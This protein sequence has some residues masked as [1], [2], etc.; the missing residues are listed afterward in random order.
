MWE[1]L[2]SRRLFDRKLKGEA[3]AEAVLSFDPGKLLEEDLTVPDGLEPIIERS[4][5]AR[6]EQ[7]YDTALEF[8]EDINDYAY[9]YGIRLLDAHF[10]KF[11][12]NMLERQT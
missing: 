1:L 12:A 3:L 9:E 10:A 4:L 7:R 8:L 11:V 6:P 5:A 2:T